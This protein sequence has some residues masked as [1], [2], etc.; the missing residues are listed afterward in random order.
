MAAPAAQ[1]FR[2]EPRPGGQLRLWSV[3]LTL[4]G[5]VGLAVAAAHLPAVIPSGANL[6][7]PEQVMY[8]RN[9]WQESQTSL[10]VL[11]LFIPWVGYG[12]LLRGAPWGR[13]AVLLLAGVGVG[14]GVWMTIHSVS[15]YTASPRYVMGVVTRI[16]GRQI[17]LA[18]RPAQSFY[19]VVSE[20]ELRAAQSWVR[21][22]N[23]VGMWVAPNSQAGFIGRPSGGKPILQS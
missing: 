14:L 4:A 7:D 19:L 5:S 8:A 10:L 21:P 23:V 12:L 15:L 22:G 9:I 3:G 6:R 18:A 13:L 2:S 20:A 11:A 17:M 16:D 1:F